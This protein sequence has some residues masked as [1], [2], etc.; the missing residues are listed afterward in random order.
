MQD[1]RTFTILVEQATPNYWVATCKDL[2][3]VVGGGP[4]REQAFHD[5]R[6][7]I[8]IYLDCETVDNAA[9]SKIELTI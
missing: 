6:K 3:R 2:P 7:K 1:R 8:Q 5:M 4:S 9:G